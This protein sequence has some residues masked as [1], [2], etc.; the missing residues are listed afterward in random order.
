MKN[1]AR[2]GPGR[3]PTSLGFIEE[4]RDAEGLQRFSGNPRDECPADAVAG[5]G[6]GFEKSD[7]QSSAT[8]TDPEG[9][10]RDAAADDSEAT[11]HHAFHASKRY[12]PKG[13]TVSRILHE[14]P[15]ASVVANSP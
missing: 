1:A 15:R 2:V 14:G 9:E 6:G 10:P 12:A 4:V 13:V 7:G 8:Q 3:C 11:I 5:I